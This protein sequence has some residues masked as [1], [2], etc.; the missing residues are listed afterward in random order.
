[1]ASSTSSSSGN[2]LDID[3]SWL[4]NVAMTNKVLAAWVAS[5]RDAFLTPGSLRPLVIMFS[6]SLDDGVPASHKC[7]G[8][9]LFLCAPRRAKKAR[10]SKPPRFLAYEHFGQE[11]V[12]S[13]HQIRFPYSETTP[14]GMLY[15]ERHAAPGQS[16]SELR[17]R[18]RCSDWWKRRGP[19]RQETR[20]ENSVV[21]MEGFTLQVTTYWYIHLPKWEKSGSLVQV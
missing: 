4:C 21:W 8:K 18:G 6:F 11:D 15:I 14:G 2:A 9:S 17:C 12:P 1:M 5:G 16:A 7:Y 20:R 10:A 3:Y 19:S 13:L